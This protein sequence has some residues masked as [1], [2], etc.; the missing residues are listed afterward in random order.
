MENKDT[1]T[2][3]PK[4]ILTEAQKKAVKKHKAKYADKYALLNRKYA[5]TYYV[6]NKELV[7]QK[8]RERYVKKKAEKLAEKQAKQ[9]EVEEVKEV[10]V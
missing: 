5:N 8:Q 1:P 6:K 4:R 2:I 10:D 9:A 7:K 3:K